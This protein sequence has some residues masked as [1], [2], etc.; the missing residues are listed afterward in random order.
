M[1]EFAGL[2]VIDNLRRDEVQA[3][4]WRALLQ[5]PSREEMLVSQGAAAMPGKRVIKLLL[6]LRA[7]EPCI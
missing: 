7:D 6:D 4:S 1:K 3:V 5:D 2:E